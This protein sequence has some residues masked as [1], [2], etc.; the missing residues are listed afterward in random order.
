MSSYK[1]VE[2]KCLNQIMKDIYEY[3][4]NNTAETRKSEKVTVQWVK[5]V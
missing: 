2:N 1:D 4:K 3:N 5:Y